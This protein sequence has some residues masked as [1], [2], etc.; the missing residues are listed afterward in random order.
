[1]EAVFFFFRELRIK[2]YFPKVSDAWRY[3]AVTRASFYYSS[4][5]WFSGGGVVVNVVVIVIIIMLFLS[6]L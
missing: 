6:L 5:L 4:S 1:M 3:V 2:V